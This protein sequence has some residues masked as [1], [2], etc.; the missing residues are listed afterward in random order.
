MSF[1][2]TVKTL[3]GNRFCTFTLTKEN[4][5]SIGDKASFMSEEL[6]HIQVKV[7]ER[8]FTYNFPKV[9]DPFYK[10]LGKPNAYGCVLIVEQLSEAKE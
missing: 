2:I 8:D 5:P 3:E 4:I 10:H 6:G 7:T 1:E 9:T